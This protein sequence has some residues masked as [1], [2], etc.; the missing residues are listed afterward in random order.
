MRKITQDHIQFIDTY[1]KKSDVVF[2]D[3]RLEMV[4]HVAATLELEMAKDE[5]ST[6]YDVFK[7][8]MVAH[9]SELLDSNKKFIKNATKRVGRHMLK[10]AW[11]K[12]GI[13]I[14]ILMALSLYVAHNVLD[15]KEFYRLLLYG[16]LGVLLIA[17]IGIRCYRVNG[18][19]FKIAAVNGLVFCGGFI[20][21][22]NYFFLNPFYFDEIRNM[23]LNKVYF[24]T[25]LILWFV[26][27]IFMLTAFQLSKSYAAKYRIMLE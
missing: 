26:S 16:P 12:N 17:S 7:A 20:S 24:F 1:L 3:I 5:R 22:L 11:S 21:Q 8:Y 23:S 27:L 19:P 18:K 25:C 15:I 2:D 4:D 9:K 6:F 14:L 13:F 10:N